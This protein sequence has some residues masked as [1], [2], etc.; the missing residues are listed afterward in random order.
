ML[1]DITGIEPKDIPCNDTKV[2]S[3][4]TSCD[5]MGVTKEQILNENGVVGIP[6]FGTN[7]VRKMVL[8][9]HP[10][11]FADLI[12][13]SGLILYKNNLGFLPFF[14]LANLGKT[15]LPTNDKRFLL[16]LVFLA[17]LDNST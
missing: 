12:Q 3:L 11:T 14:S 15:C 2:F 16:S 9:A 4:F 17:N 13:I 7:F 1:K 5:A 6:E 10:T 8:E